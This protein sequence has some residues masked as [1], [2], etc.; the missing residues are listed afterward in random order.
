MQ[1]MQKSTVRWQQIGL[2]SVFA[3]VATAV[4]LLTLHSNARALRIA[5]GAFGC[6]AFDTAV[7]IAPEG[8][9]VIPMVPAR[10]SN[11]AVI[12]KNLRIRGG[13]TRLGTGN[14]SE[15]NEDITGTQNLNDA[16]YTW[17]GPDVRSTLTHNGSESV[18][19]IDPAVDTVLIEHMIFEHT[20]GLA[21]NGGG[22]SGTIDSG[23]EVRLNN[24]IISK[25][26]ALDTGG[27]LYMTLRG[28]SRLEILNSRFFENTAD[29][30][31]GF[32]IH[33]EEN[34][35]LDIR[36][37]TVSTNTASSGNGGGGHIIIASGYVTITNGRFFGNT[38]SGS[39]TGLSIEKTGSAPATVTLINTDTDGPIHQTGTNLTVR[40]LNENVYLPMVI[41]D[42][43]PGEKYAE[44]TDITINDD[45]QYVIDY[46][47]GNFTPSLSDFHVHFFFNT[48]ST[49]NA[50]T[51][52]SGPWRAVAS[53]SPYTGLS[54]QDKP[55]L[56]TEM[57]ILVANSSHA[58][59]P[60]TGNCYPLPP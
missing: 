22:I 19:T 4:L 15:T 2:I 43:V 5:S 39:G 42:P 49:A 53:P 23:A 32:E 36:G 44:I 51:P 25:T 45:Y 6:G 17:L 33:V 35:H 11:G 54:P 60:G 28:G 16:G 8:K 56:A 57:C 24:V 40:T 58:I 21:D 37:T 13:W 7:A 9:T 3:V 10:S 14:C 29:Q 48:V 34:S 50:G 20:S 47:V 52:G 27:G 55:V 12:S 41:K 46:Q 1:L 31:G 38:A 26:G 30:G 18:I 59:L